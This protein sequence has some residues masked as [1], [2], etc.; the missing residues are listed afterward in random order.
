MTDKRQTG[1][2]PMDESKVKLTP[3]QSGL[4]PVPTTK[5]LAM[6]N[7]PMPLTLEQ[8]KA[9]GHKEVSATVLLYLAG[10]IDQWWYRQD[11]HGVVFLLNVTSIDE[12]HGLLESLPFGQAKLL[13]FDLL[14][15]GPL[16][17]LQVLLDH[18]QV[19]GR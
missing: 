1:A 3:A 17:P 10:K 12:A 11:G 8:R 19:T 7:I 16:S 6:G 18:P 5:I 4:P 2:A 9:L 14:P 15:L 13:K